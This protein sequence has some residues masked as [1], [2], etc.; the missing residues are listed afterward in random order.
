MAS[1]REDLRALV[2]LNLQGRT[3]LDSAIDAALDDACTDVT[4]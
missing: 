2:R 3:D 1:T 4:N